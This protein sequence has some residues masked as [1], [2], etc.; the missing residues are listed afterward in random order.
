M[1]F[2]YYLF[3]LDNCL[4]NFKDPSEYFDNVLV[5]TIKRL[6]TSPLP[7]RKERNK[8]WLSGEKYID[9]LENWGL[10]DINHFWKHF[11]EIDF[12]LRKLHLKQDE[13]SLYHDVNDVLNRLKDAGKKIA[14]ISNAADYI[15]DYIVQK[16]QILDIFD[17]IF[18]LGFDK[19]QAIAKPSPYGVLKVL[20][21]LNFNP[22]K[23]KAIMI[24]DSRLDIY[25]AKRA[26]IVACLITRELNK[27]PDGYKKWIYKPDYVIEQLDEIF[28]IN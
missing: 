6:T 16:F 1:K 25:A 8:F 4:L 21:N 12:E 7:G 10:N 18:G 22:D 26:N 27:Y 20:K 28:D 17:D 15:V 19:D 14:I 11:D 5:E 13:L 23:S 9:M 2:D 24:G 3:D